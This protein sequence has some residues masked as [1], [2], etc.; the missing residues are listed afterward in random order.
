[1]GCYCCEG[2]PPSSGSV[3]G[4]LRGTDT[5]NY[6]VV[7]G[8]IRNDGDD[9]YTI[10][11]AAHGPVNVDGVSSSS[12]AITI[13]HAA[14]CATRVVSFYVGPDD[15][16]A[17]VGVV[18]GASVGLGSTNITLTQA[19]PYAD[20]VYYK[21]T[22]PAGWISANGVFD[23]AFTPATGALT[24]SHPA[25]PGP[26]YDVNVTGRGALLAAPGSVG[27]S[28]LVVQWRDYTGALVTTPT[29]SHQAFISHGAS[30]PLDPSRVTTDI[31]PGSNLWFVGVFEVEGS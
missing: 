12:T 8:V 26:C 16:L 1:M 20:F 4:A 5:G 28:S 9:W 30:G 6:R 31:F 3:A 18:A 24:L 13:N 25:I 27:E 17:K 2:P 7:A 11:D 14:I 22:A 29:S 21:A 19:R 23:L 15:T 10:D